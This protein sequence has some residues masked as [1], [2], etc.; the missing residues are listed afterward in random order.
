MEFIPFNSRAGE[1]G[2]FKPEEMSKLA[3]FAE[4]TG[5]EHAFH[6]NNGDPMFRDYYLYAGSASGKLLIDQPGMFGDFEGTLAHWQDELRALGPELEIYGFSYLHVDEA[7]R[8]NGKQERG[9][10]VYVESRSLRSQVYYLPLQDAEEVAAAGKKAHPMLR[11]WVPS[12]IVL[13]DQLAG[14]FLLND[15]QG[16]PIP[17]VKRPEPE[18]VAFGPVEIALRNLGNVLFKASSPYHAALVLS[19]EDAE[20]R[21]VMVEADGLEALHDRVWDELHDQAESQDSFR[22]YCFAVD[23][24][25]TGEAKER[26]T[27]FLAQ[28]EYRGQKPTI[29]GYGIKSINLFGETIGLM[30]NPTEPAIFERPP[31]RTL[32][33]QE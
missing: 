12:G 1:E 30:Q 26:N 25:L 21:H 8:A 5:F 3:I 20:D 33:V 28:M 14:W 19:Y 17:S 13:Q 9:L 18:V 15:E 22:G 4:I 31:V 32:Y 16:R 24:F 11:H 7:K 23:A 6:L 10:V 29:K 2:F 27:V